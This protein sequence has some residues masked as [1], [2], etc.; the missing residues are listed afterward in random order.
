MPTHHTNR[1]EAETQGDEDSATKSEQTTSIPAIHFAPSQ[2][3]CTAVPP[4]WSTGDDPARPPIPPPGKL[5]ARPRQSPGPE[6][7]PAKG[8][9]NGQAANVEGDRRK[10]DCQDEGWHVWGRQA[11]GKLL[12]AHTSR[13]WLTKAQWWSK[14]ARQTP[15]S[16]Q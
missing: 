1:G 11:I 4:E 10:E 8:S 7:A 13:V 12:S 9:I 6:E 15:H 3:D 2:S 5:L 16:E 14:P